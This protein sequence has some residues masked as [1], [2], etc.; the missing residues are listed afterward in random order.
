MS[1][2]TTTKATDALAEDRRRVQGIEDDD[3]G[4]S[5]LTTGLV[6][7][8]QK[9]SVYFPCFQVANSNTVLSL[10]NCCLVFIL[11]SSYPFF[12]V[13]CLK[14][15]QYCNYAENVFV[16]NVHLPFLCTPYVQ[17]SLKTKSSRYQ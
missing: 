2:K 17:K 7:W 15:Y 8:Q 12:F 11:F 4:G 14:Y 9:R 1:K 16:P 5:R 13:G 3:G 10:S 6:D